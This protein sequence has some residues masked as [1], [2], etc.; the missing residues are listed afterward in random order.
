MKKFI[1][2]AMVMMLPVITIS[3]CNTIK[4]MGQDIQSG[5]TTVQNAMR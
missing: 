3:A 1:L 5:A 2:I 4:G